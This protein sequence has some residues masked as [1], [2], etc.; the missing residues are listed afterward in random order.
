MEQPDFAMGKLEL[1]LAGWLAWAVTGDTLGT[2]APAI[3]FSHSS[4]VRGVDCSL[5]SPLPTR[6]S[7]PSC[8]LRASRPNSC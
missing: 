1:G 2:V 6:P 3:M 5:P 4:P 8:V 7:N